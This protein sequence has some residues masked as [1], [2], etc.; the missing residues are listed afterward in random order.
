VQSNDELRRDDPNMKKY[1][2]IAEAAPPRGLTEKA[3]RQKIFR[4][5]LPYRKLGRRVL[6][7]ADELERFLAALPGKT[8]EEAVA[9]AEES[10]G[11]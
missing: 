5:Q 6:I 11:W 3:V 4:G 2:T 7:P 9:A 8:A 1:L 10:R